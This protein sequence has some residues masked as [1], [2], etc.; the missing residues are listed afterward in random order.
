[1]Y[2]VSPI[3]KVGFK[4]LNFFMPSRGIIG[5]ILKILIFIYKID[6]TIEMTKYYNY[7]FLS[8]LKT[9]GIQ[10]ILYVHFWQTLLLYQGLSFW[11]TSN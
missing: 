2:I 11:Q 8:G 1:M 10:K 5:K 9:K 3:Y 6:N 4:D 7:G